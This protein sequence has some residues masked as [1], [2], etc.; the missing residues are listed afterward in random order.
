MCCCEIFGAVHC[1]VE[2]NE[3]ILLYVTFLGATW[4]LQKNR[5]VRM[6]LLVQRLNERAQ[7]IV[8]AVMHLLAALFSL[9]LTYYG[10]VVT[11]DQF[12]RQIYG[13]SLLEI[14]NVYILWVIPLGFFLL[15]IQF[16]RISFQSLR[17]KPTPEDKIKVQGDQEGFIQ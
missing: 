16:L 15:A 7:R 2:I 5:H 3:I 13:F 9:L 14:P 4:A 8:N 17:M 10:I 12:K 6:D 11:V 1:S